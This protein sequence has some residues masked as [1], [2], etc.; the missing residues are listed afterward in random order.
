MGFVGCRLVCFVACCVWAVRRGAARSFGADASR[1][2]PGSYSTTSVLKC[3]H[4]LHVLTVY[5]SISI[6]SR[7]KWRHRIRS[8]NASQTS[9]HVVLRRPALISNSSCTPRQDGWSQ[10]KYSLYFDFHLP[11]CTVWHDWRCPVHIPIHHLPLRVGDLAGVR[12][13]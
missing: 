5:S 7:G 10:D 4:C 3:V 2:N 8:T 6:T 11:H 1:A 12:E 13:Y 9:K